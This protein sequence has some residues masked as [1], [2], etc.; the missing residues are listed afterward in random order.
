VKFSP[1]IAATAVALVAFAFVGT[2][3]AGVVVTDVPGAAVPSVDRT[4]TF[5][6]VQTFT[7]L[8]HYS[9]DGLS[10]STP[11]F[12]DEFTDPPGFNGGFFYG[13]GGQFAPITITTTDAAKIFGI[14]LNVGSGFGGNVGTIFVAYEI[15]NNNAIIASGTL[16]LG[17][18]SIL[19]FSDS[20]GFD[21]V[22]FGTYVNSSTAALVDSNFDNEENAGALDNVEADLTGST[23]SVPEPTTLALFALGLVGLGVIRRRHAA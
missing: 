3:H 4:A 13:S 19:G 10:I 20:I 22:L 9:E 14:Q 7:D 2:A 12:A 16:D 6:A 18:G 1:S 8:T 17:Q 15:L 11:N 5:D 21:T 23:S